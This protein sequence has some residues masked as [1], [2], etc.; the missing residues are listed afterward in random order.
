MYRRFL[1]NNDY[2][3][4][5]TPEALTQLTRGN[6]ER[7]FQ[8][9]EA[10]EISII[11]HLSENYEI[12]REL[13]KGKFIA[14]YDRRITFPVG[15]HIYHDGQIYEVIRSIS[16]CR[17]PST[18]SYWEECIT[19]PESI[20][21]LHNYSQFAT[22]YKE[23]IVLY[24]NVPYICLCENGYKFG[25]IRIPLVSGW[26]EAIPVPW[27]PINFALWE[28]VSFEGAFY[29]L[30]SLKNFDNN[31]N[32]YLSNNWGAIADYEPS[33]NEYELSDH[34]YVVFENRV[35]YPENDVNADIPQPGT[36]LSLHD[37][38]NYNL[39]K[40]MLR[41]A[42]YELSKLV[43]PNNV[44]LVRMRDYEDSM[45]WLSDTAKLR[46]NPQITRKL[47]ED[48]KPIMDWQLSTFQT[49]YDPYKNP[50]LT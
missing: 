13:T 26:L 31:Q 32:P 50:W 45:K 7:F 8:A 39:K 3:A 19:P 41:L 23:N 36:N 25:D 40:H 17:R 15:S 10:A 37:P 49:N 14:T 38:R 48:K 28:V 46:I 33:C 16:G 2:L 35:F 43:A 20:D 30:M 47:S 1:N 6:E 11:E 12:E 9:E 42:I 34:E 24:N 44:S 4:I 22:Y 5:I 27:Q 18:R 21:N 29:T